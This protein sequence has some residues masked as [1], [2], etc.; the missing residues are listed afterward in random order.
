[1]NEAIKAY[2]LKRYYN[3]RA[4]QISRGVEF[5]ITEEQYLALWT[6]KKAALN[7]LQDQYDR[8]VLMNYPFEPKT[9]L[10]L[11]WKKDMIRRG[12][13]MSIETAGLYTVENSKLNCRLRKDEKKSEAAKAK[14]RKPK[15]TT[16]N[17]KGPKAPWSEERKA[18]R[19]F[20]MA[21]RKRGPYKTGDVS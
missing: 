10:V 6:R 2:L 18:A 9:N 11:S 4:Y 20:A 5:L 19:A 16:E 13:P 21:G 17:M 3:S 14:L 12:L 8:S 1:M 15:S 7:R